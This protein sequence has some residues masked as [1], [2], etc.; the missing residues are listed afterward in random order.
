MVLSVSSVEEIPLIDPTYPIV[1]EPFEYEKRGCEIN[2]VLF[3]PIKGVKYRY[4]YVQLTADIQDKKY[5]GVDIW[6]QLARDDLF[7]LIAFIL[8]IPNCNH[9]FIVHACR[10]ADRGPLS[11][12][13]E[14]YAREHFKS[15]IFTIAEPIKRLLLNPE[16]RICIFSY[17]ERAA[18][19]FLRAVKLTLEGSLFLK[20]L[21][22]EILYEDPC[23]QAPKWGETEGIYIKRQTA[24]KEASLE[25][26]GLVEGM[27]TGKHYSGRIYDD[28]ETADSVYNPEQA[29]RLKDMFDLS[30]NL[31]T[32]DGWHRIIGTPYSN[33]GLLMYCIGKKDLDGKPI[34]S[35]RKRPATEDGTP[36]GKSVFLPEL[37]LA[38][39]RGNRQMFFSQQLCDPT[40]QSEIL[41]NGNDLKEI[42]SGELPKQMYKFMTVD[43]AGFRKDR[44]GDSWGIFC[45]GVEPVLDDIGASNI[46]ILDA[47]IEVMNEAD[48]HDTIVKMYTSNGM[49]LKLGVEKVSMMTA[50]IHIA[51]ALRLKGR[52]VS[53]ENGSLT[54]L[55]PGGR[56]KQQR[57]ESS[58]AWPLRNGKIHILK[59]IP[60]A[61]RER[62]RIEMSKFPFGH[63]DD[64]LDALSYVYDILKEYRFPK[65]F[66]AANPQ[67]KRDVWDQ[68][69][70]EL[71]KPTHGWLYV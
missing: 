62:L 70:R 57:I 2:G 12:T 28:V 16:E 58:L 4:D 53:I 7:W 30:Q 52:N 21:F 11:H 71:D 22:P 33:E 37:K 35:L 20:V 51:N 48:A 36:N 39:L 17:T 5:H 66:T 32:R 29:Q 14:M 45:I 25:A 10:D 1:S 31:G 38:E 13:I 64:G 63:H 40:P 55:R 42:W 41:L 50:E 47:C 69:F 23:T 19:G 34:Y 18:R 3:H 56:S 24:A 43:P 26:Y 59:S 6:R 8:K 54:L 49:I 60:N 68:A 67:G 9:P 46:Y 15:S 65:R 61:Y 44:T 27:P